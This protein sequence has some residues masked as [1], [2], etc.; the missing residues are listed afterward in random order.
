MLAEAYL[1]AGVE[2]VQD[3]K[4]RRRVLERIAIAPQGSQLERFP[5]DEVV[6]IANQ[7]V[8]QIKYNFLSEAYQ[9]LYNHPATVEWV[10]LVERLS[11]W[12][13][14]N[15]LP[16][17]ELIALLHI[18]GPDPLLVKMAANTD[19][20]AAP[21]PNFTRLKIKYESQAEV[22]LIG[23]S[24]RTEGVRTPGGNAT[25]LQILRVLA[26]T[27]DIGRI[28][29][30]IADFMEKRGKAPPPQDTTT[31]PEFASLSRRLAKRLTKKEEEQ[32]YADAIK[33]LNA[34][35]DSL[36]Q[37]IA[38]R[39]GKQPTSKTALNGGKTE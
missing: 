6:P 27:K 11:S 7:F 16:I 22:A 14:M 12:R 31:W 10:T 37:A 32:P 33:A 30:N 8:G 4:L 1:S 13:Q 39:E 35:A 9:W 3:R 24:F 5:P 26:D 38:E 29:W 2:L 23:L 21:G 25:L 36:E 17:W 18:H 28:G 20:Y 15:P 19:M 34:W